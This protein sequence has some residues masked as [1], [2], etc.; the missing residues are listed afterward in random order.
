MRLTAKQLS[1]AFIETV[2]CLVL[3]P[4]I[5]NYLGDLGVFFIILE[6]MAL[7]PSRKIPLRLPSCF[8]SIQSMWTRSSNPKSGGTS[9]I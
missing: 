7:K 9:E 5:A 8:F 3:R 4:H 1:R 2:S 6:L